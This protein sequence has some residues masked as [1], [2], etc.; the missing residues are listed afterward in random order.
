MDDPVKFP[1][2]HK[3]HRAKGKPQNQSPQQSAQHADETEIS[4][5]EGKVQKQK[6][7]QSNENE[8]TVGKQGVSGPER[9]EK[10][11]KNPKNDAQNTALQKLSGGD[12]RGHYRKSRES[13][14]PPSF[15]SS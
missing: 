7:P 9:P 4:P 5:A 11:I 8:Q 14:L 12:F 1:E 10:F 6:S 2:N 15:G 3:K 13:Q